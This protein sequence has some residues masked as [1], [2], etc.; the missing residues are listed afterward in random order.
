MDGPRW[1]CRVSPLNP[2]EVANLTEAPDASSAFDRYLIV[3]G[4]PLLASSWTRGVGRKAFLR[5]ALADDRTPLA[6]TALQILLSEF[7]RELQ[8][9][10]VVEAI[11]HGES[12]YSRIQARS[13]VKGN[14]LNEA[15]EVLVEKKILVS[16]R[17][18]LRSSPRQEGAAVRRGRP[19]SSLLAPL[20]RPSPGRDLS[21]EGRISS[22]TG[23]SA[24][25]PHTAGGRSS[26]WCERRWSGSSTIRRPPNASAGRATWVDGGD[27]TTPSRSTSSAATSRS[28]AALASLVQS[29]GVTEG[30]SRPGTWMS[31]QPPERKCPVPRAPSSSPSAAAASPR[32]STRMQG[33]APTSSWRPGRERPS[34]ACSTMTAPR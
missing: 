10:D 21:R 13:G 7:P 33:S 3:G 30:A 4:F 32:A 22:L 25:G 14:T 28:R 9:R 20:R 11:G 8:V 5:K 12:A 19:L 29:S 6:A 17:P 34:A 2:A 27:A 16:A 24:T 26:R 23:S 31:W 15:L 18:S 1:S